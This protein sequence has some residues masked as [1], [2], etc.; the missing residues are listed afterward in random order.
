MRKTIYIIFM[1]NHNN[2]YGYVETLQEAIQVCKE[3][4]NKDNLKEKPMMIERWHFVEIMNVPKVHHLRKEIK[5]DSF[6]NIPIT[7]GALI[8]DDINR[9]N[10]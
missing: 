2:I 1:P 3:M 5:A 8:D 4:N 9:E 10:G 7:A 6:K